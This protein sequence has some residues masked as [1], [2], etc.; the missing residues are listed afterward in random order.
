MS[1]VFPL[2]PILA[3]LIPIVA[4]VMT[5]W[6]KVQERKMDLMEKGTMDMDQ[7]TQAVLHMRDAVDELAQTMLV[8]HE[9]PLAAAGW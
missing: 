2:I 9:R 6:R 3:L 1:N 5:N 4:L 8:A 7:A